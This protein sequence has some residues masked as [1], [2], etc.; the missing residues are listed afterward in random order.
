LHQCQWFDGTRPCGALVAGTKNAI[1]QHLQTAHGLRLKADKTMQV[2]HWEGCRKSMRRESIA[3]HILAV[4]MLDKVLC[5]SC[6]SRF[7]RTDSMQR[8]Q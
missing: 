3:R 7:A 1:G 5:P 4:H 2:C 6:R 8:H